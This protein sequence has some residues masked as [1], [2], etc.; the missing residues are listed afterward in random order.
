MFT[1]RACFIKAVVKF[2]DV[3]ENIILNVVGF[4]ISCTVKLIVI[5]FKQNGLASRN[6]WNKLALHSKQFPFVG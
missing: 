4:E 1:V 2:S 5:K 3:V 6:V